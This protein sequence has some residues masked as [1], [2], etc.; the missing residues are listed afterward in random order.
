LAGFEVILYGR[1]WVI[2]E[3]EQIELPLVTQFQL[4]PF[5]RPA[6]GCGQSPE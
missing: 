1:F 5:R 4:D 6:G 2:P 3:V